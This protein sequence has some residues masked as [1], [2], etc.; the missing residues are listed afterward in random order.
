MS[1]EKIQTTDQ[2]VQELVPG[3]WCIGQKLGGQVHA[4]LCDDGG[5]LTLIDTLF[6]TK[7]TRILA[8]IDQIGRKPSDLKH[9]ILSHSHR[10]HLG[11]MAALKELSGA[12]V[13][14]HEWEADII[15]GERKAQPVGLIP[16]RPYR[17]YIP[18]QLGLSLGLGKHA[19]CK[20]DQFVVG[21]DRVGP[22]EIVDAE[23]HSPG[24]LAFLWPERQA[25]IA[26]DAVATW[27]GLM[28]GWPAF[29]L[30]ERRHRESLRRMADVEPVVLGVG[31][32]PPITTG[33]RECIRDLIDE[34]GS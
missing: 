12:S 32:G 29:N 9:I 18:F 11:G 31:H 21:G 28:P 8:L 19:P 13:Y 6:D 20:V 22:I 16:G 24:H 5:E 27:P 25:L 30:N 7:P 1:A 3:L 15:A 33:A 4:F 17:A 23:G 10:S 2:P 26:G 34:L 14:A